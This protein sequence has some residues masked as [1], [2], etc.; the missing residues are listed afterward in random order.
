LLGVLLD[1]TSVGGIIIE[2]MPA[3]TATA[4]TSRLRA[5]DALLW[6]TL[7]SAFSTIFAVR[8]VDGPGQVFFVAFHLLPMFAAAVVGVFMGIFL[9]PYLKRWIAP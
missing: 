5:V 7:A 4:L 2:V 3:V 1:I 8:I 6:A 9:R